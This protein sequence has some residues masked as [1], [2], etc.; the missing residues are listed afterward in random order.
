MARKANSIDNYE[1]IT[2]A[3][4][5]A[6]ENGVAPWI[7]PWDRSLGMPH[8]GASNHIYQGINVWLCFARSW[9]E[10]WNDP[11]F[12][13]YNQVKKLAT[14]KG[15]VKTPLGTKAETT[16]T[17]PDGPHV[18]KGEH[19]VRIVK[20]LFL[21]PKQK[22]GESDADYTKRKNSKVPLLK[23]FTVFNTAQIEWGED[24]APKLGDTE[25][26]DLEQVNAEATEFLAT[27]GADIK[28]GGTRAAYNP[29][30]DT[31]Q[32]PAPETF[33]T[34]GD[35]FCT[36]FHEVIHWT[37]HKGRCDRDLKGRFG[38]D[39][40]AAE[41]LVAELG[42]AFLCGDYQI[43]GKLQHDEYIGHWLKVLKGDKYAIFTAA[44][45]ARDAAN[46][47]KVKPV[48]KAKPAKKAGKARK[49]DKVA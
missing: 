39:A 43:E 41:E 47:T 2:N 40:Y 34:E 28:H 14:T 7:C 36:A 12:F 33:K 25:P 6:L 5:E 17:D 49:T 15:T 1:V 22:N 10:G 26:M 46:F 45:L 16:T 9:A 48:E 11:R 31:I 13:T 20:W 23:T 37:G 8:N 32:L 35:Y 18:R 21:T 27:M 29:K 44:R 3:I 19:G 24:G 42:A 4:I 30:T 38:T